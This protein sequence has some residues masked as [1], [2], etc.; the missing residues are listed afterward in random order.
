M[1]AAGAGRVCPADYRYTPEVFKRTP[2]FKTEVLYAA[3]GLYGNPGALDAIE[4]LLAEETTPAMLIC[5]G[6]FHWFDAEPDWFD[7]IDRRVAGHAA[8][9]GNVETEIARAGDIGAG[10]GCAYPSGVAT[11]TV[12]R[13]NRILSELRAAAPP[14]L[15]AHLADLPMHGVATVGELKIGII[16]GDAESLAGWNFAYERLA[17]ADAGER[18]R[19]LRERSGIDVFACSHTCTAALCDLPGP[20]G[21]TV[22]NN[23][24]A[25]MPNFSGLR[26]GVVTRI[27]VSP[28]PRPP[29]YGV[30]R[31]GVHIDALPV[32]YDTETF[33]QRFLARWPPGSPAYASYYRRL[34]DGPAQALADAVIRESD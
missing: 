31:R 16:H 21:L 27:G 20:R 28:P 12:E 8:L 6:D 5:N 24:A 29:L 19:T 4:A 13:S 33:L 11:E 30:T 23:G 22:I 17:A 2:E 14:R 7:D 34:L 32:D 1:N 10:C 25:G 3:G 18:L 26:C 15:A 9:R